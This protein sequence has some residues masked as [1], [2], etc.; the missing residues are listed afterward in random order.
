MRALLRSLAAVVTLVPGVARSAQ[1][2]YA[3]S[4]LASGFSAGVI[5]VNPVTNQVYVG[6]VAVNSSNMNPGG[7]PVNAGLTVIDAASKATT[8]IGSGI[9]SDIEVNAVTNKIYAAGDGAIMVVDGATNATAVL[10]IGSGANPVHVA[11]NPVTNKIYAIDLTTA[12]VTVVDG[13]TNAITTVPVGGVPSAVAV[14]EVTDQIYVTSANATFVTVIDGETNAV[15]TVQLAAFSSAVAV[16]PVTNKIY[17]VDSGL[18]VIDGATLATTSLATGNGFDRLAVNPVT[19]KVYA[20]NPVGSAITVIDGA[21]NAVS[22]VPVGTGSNGFA[23]NPATNQ[24]FVTFVGTSD[25]AVIDGN[26]NAV[27]TITGVGTPVWSLI[28]EVFPGIALNPVSNTVF[29]PTLSGVYEIGGN[30]QPGIP[31]FSIQPAAETLSLGAP[32]ALNAL[33]AGAS[34]ATYQW[35][36]DE[37]PLSDGGGIEGSSTPTLFLSGGAAF[38]DTGCYRCVVTNGSGSASSSEV[39]LSVVNSPA[40]GRITNLSTRAFVGTGSDVMISGFVVSGSGSKQLVLRGVGPALGSFG[41]SGT[42][43]NPVLWLFDSASPSNLITNDSGWQNPPLAPDGPWAGKV[44]PV[45]ATAADFSDVGA[46]GLPAQSADAAIMIPLPAGSYTAQVTGASTGTGVA[47][48]EIYDA[49]TGTP[50]TQLANI[51]SRAFVGNAGDNLTAGFVI[52]GSTSETVLIRASG[53]ALGAFGLTHLLPD[54]QLQLFD[55]SQNLIASSFGWGG[56]SIIASVAASAGAFAWSDPA[57]DDSALLVTLHPGAYTAEVSGHSG[58]TGI[59]LIEVYA[60]PAVTNG[61]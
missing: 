60:V 9:W 29:I 23:V 22:T 37:A 14:N 16:N 28:Q 57:S 53:P 5:A 51:S 41:V 58:D 46:F 38:S 27:S 18:T 52:G 6:D 31:S 4:S 26:T 2:S 35:L 55:G 45:E 33:A 54:P 12:A 44:V 25:V 59:A 13:A 34:S 48:A 7:F 61:P 17:V 39:P 36:K 21:T 40:P 20:T 15:R 8:T 49:D 32:A 43:A 42:L 19:N 56:S 1:P 50:N 24:I 3:A 30:L 47:L 11:V 10:P